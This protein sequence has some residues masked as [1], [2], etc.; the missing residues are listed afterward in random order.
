M[1]WSLHT[2][3]DMNTIH[4]VLLVLTVAFLIANAL[5]KLQSWPWGLTLTV[6]LALLT[7]GAKP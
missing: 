3:L 7:F 5:G 1:A 2:G 6:W 4:L